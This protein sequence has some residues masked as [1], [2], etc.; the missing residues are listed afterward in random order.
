MASAFAIEDVARFSG[1]FAFA[2]VRVDATPGVGADL[3]AADDLLLGRN[4]TFF[5][6]FCHF[7]VSI[8]ESSGQPDRQ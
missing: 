2:P 8:G 3:V 7:H 4:N 5:L 6:S 1:A